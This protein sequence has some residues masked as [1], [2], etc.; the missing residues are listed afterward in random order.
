MSADRLSDISTNGKA[1]VEVKEE[2][3]G[4]GG[5]GEVCEWKDA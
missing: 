5:R 3:G 2:E 1:E 4:L